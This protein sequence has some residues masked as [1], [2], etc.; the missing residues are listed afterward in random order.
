MA[1]APGVDA[2]ALAVTCWLTGADAGLRVS[3]AT[4]APLAVPALKVATTAPK[5]WLEPD[6]MVIDWP[7]VEEERESSRPL[8]AHQLETADSRRVKPAP[9]VRPLP[10]LVCPPTPTT[11]SPAPP[12][13]AVGPACRELLLPLPVVTWSSADVV[14]VP[15]YSAMVTAPPPPATV[16]VTLPALEFWR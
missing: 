2:E 7:A 5:Y 13:A 8:T 4:G 9:A 15:E 1:W 14:A 3:A 6:V 12:M 16:T 11:S 10:T